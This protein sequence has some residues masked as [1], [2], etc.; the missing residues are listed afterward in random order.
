MPKVLLINGSP[1]PNG[2]T[3]HMLTWLKN[4]LEENKLEVELYQIAGKKINL[5]T[6][7]YSCIKTGKCVQQEE[8]YVEICQK[9]VEADA[10]VF[11]TPTYNTS[12]TMQLKILLD[13]VGMSIGGQ[14][15]R[16]IGTVI[17]TAERDGAIL[18]FDTVV[19]WM[20]FYGM[21]I[22]TG[23]Y[24]ND[25]YCPDMLSKD[26]VENDQM[27]KKSMKILSE[28]LTYIIEKFQN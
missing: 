22:V 19:N 15:K 21:Y 13:R 3:F 20:A 17:T 12:I 26:G 1:R 23:F 2:N 18:A 10:V 5:C 6:G 28:N 7:C 25:G 8:D 27:A 9:I 24:W 4:H 14:L 11:G 16:K